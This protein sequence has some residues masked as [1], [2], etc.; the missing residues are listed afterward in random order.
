[1][2]DN[3]FPL[4]SAPQPS[5]IHALAVVIATTGRKEITEQT[6]ASLALR[7]SLPS[8]VIVAG[9]NQGDLPVFSG[10]LPFQIQLLISPR[11]GSAVQRNF[12]LRELPAFIE[13]VTFLDDDME[14]HD[15]YCRQVE[16]VFRHFP[17]VAGFSGHV[18]ANG[19]I[20]RVVAR[21][22]LDQRPVPPGKPIFGFYP[23][24]WPGFYGCAMNI[25]RRWLEVEQ[26]DER[27]PLYALGEDAE[28]GFRLS[29]HG[30]VGGSESCLV[31]HLATKSGR[32]SEVGIGYAQ[33]INPLYFVGKRIGFPRGSTYWQKLVK[34]PM[35]NLVFWWFPRLDAKGSFVD[36]AGRFR[37]NLLALWD[38]ARGKIDPM[39]LI[40]VVESQKRDNNK[41]GSGS[42]T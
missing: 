40:K 26:F 35:V 9:A 37:G 28:M 21:E 32:I 38:V 24:R 2:P 13:Y 15:D 10:K 12:G 41:L 4:E 5:V 6:I 11:K 34:A 30:S 33:I 23:G 14:V 16:N 19:D 1:M 42:S 31:V 7:K 29:R 8:L 36:R 25:R 20:N 17:E 39:N 3:F 18:V 22:M 27:L